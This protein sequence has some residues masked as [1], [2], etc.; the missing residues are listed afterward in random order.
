MQKRQLRSNPYAVKLHNLYAGGLMLI[1]L[2]ILQ[3]FLSLG[4]LDTTALISIICFAVALP[5]LS[6]ALVLNI[7]ESRYQY[8]SSHRAVSLGV[9]FA[10]LL[11]AFIDVVGISSAF[12]HT[13]WVAG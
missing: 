10:F 11:S 6:G 4:T 12:W 7:I 1:S 2:V 9:H 3:V 13:S 8:S 5:F